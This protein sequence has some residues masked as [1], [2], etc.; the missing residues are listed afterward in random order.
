MSIAT[1]S[2]FLQHP[3]W[4]RIKAQAVSDQNNT[5]IS[6]KQQISNFVKLT[7]LNGQDRK[8]YETVMLEVERPLIETTLEIT[9]GN[10]LQAAKILGINRNTLN[11]KVKELGIKPRKK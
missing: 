10:Q 5:D 6:V 9:R 2:N 1:K 7:L 8:L 4:Q 11:K 3:L